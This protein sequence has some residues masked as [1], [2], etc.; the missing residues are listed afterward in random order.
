MRGALNLQRVLD[1]G[2]ICAINDTLNSGMTTR[3]GNGGFYHS[4]KLTANRLIPM[5]QKVSQMLAS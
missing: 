2:A 4:C 5:L 3:L 1:F